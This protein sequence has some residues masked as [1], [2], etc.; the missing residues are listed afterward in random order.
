MTS[1]SST[2]ALP[3]GAAFTV[4]LIINGKE[5]TSTSTFQVISPATGAKLW[6]ASSVSA[7][8]AAEAADAAQTAFESWSQTKPA[9]RKGILLRA[10][11]L[12][13]SRKEELLSYQSHETGAGRQFMEVN[14]RAAMGILLD[15]AGRLE[16]ALQGSLPIAE[17]EGT[18][19]MMVKEPYG[20]ILA[21]APWC[22]APR[23]HLLTDFFSFPRASYAWRLTTVQERPHRFGNPLGGLRAG[24]G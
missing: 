5:I 19:A 9:Y 22:V 1:T 11:D 23:H 24:H 2:D 10:A 13:I 16:T 14:I 6:K 12:L 17:E 3:T 21:I 4:P 20:V 15:I 18:H 7:A 8:E